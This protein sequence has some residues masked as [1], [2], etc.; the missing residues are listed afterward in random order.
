MKNILWGIAA[1]IILAA[2]VQAKQEPITTPGDRTAIQAAIARGE[3]TVVFV[4]DSITAGADVPYRWSWAP[5]FAA[6]LQAAHPNVRFK[7]I[8]LS[9][10]GRSLVQALDDKYVAQDHE[11]PAPQGYYMPRG[12]T[13]LWPQ[14][15]QPGQS[16]KQAVLAQNPDLV[17][18]AF[19][20]ND[21]SGDGEAFHKVSTWLAATYQQAPS[22]PS[23]AMVATILPSRSA[24]DYQGKE[25]NIDKAA[26][27]ARDSAAE[28]HATLIDA[29]AFQKWMR[30]GKPHYA[31]GLLGGADAA[32]LGGFLIGGNGINHP[33]IIGHRLIYRQAYQPLL[34]ALKPASE[35]K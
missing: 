23:I 27:A 15:S 10:P 16:W 18:I 30:E 2:C 22:H 7:F 24:T 28:V 4:G 21:V 1:A 5:L 34:S 25:S 3:A 14:G 17:V 35:S 12:D 20:M 31:L 32:L 19:G 29:N 6:D 9:L 11:V 33:S 26:Q 13:S 8:N